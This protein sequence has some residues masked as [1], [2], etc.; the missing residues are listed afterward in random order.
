MLSDGL[1]DLIQRGIV[2]N[3]F[4]TFYPSAYVNKPAEIAKNNNLPMISVF[5]QFGFVRSLDSE[6][7]EIELIKLLNIDT[8]VNK[9]DSDNG[10]IQ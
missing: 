6:P 5:E 2:N 8:I 10:A 7:G 4:K 3:R 1:V 9:V